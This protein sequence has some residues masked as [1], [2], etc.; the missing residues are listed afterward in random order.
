MVKTKKRVEESFA[1]SVRGRIEIFTTSYCK[2]DQLSRSW[3][4][5]DGK[6]KISL[7]D[8]TSYMINQS[9]FHELSPYK[10]TI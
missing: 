10:D 6:Q 4:V 5:I 1:N 2:I 8:A 7:S 9:Y 3:T